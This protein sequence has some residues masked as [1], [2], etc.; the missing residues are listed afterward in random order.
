MKRNNQVVIKTWTSEIV[1]ESRP[2]PLK[3][4]M[5]LF[6]MTIYTTQTSEQDLGPHREWDV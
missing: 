4:K 2:A 3:A 6:V 5:E 1:Y